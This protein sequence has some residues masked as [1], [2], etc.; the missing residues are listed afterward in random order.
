[1]VCVHSALVTFRRRV[2]M[3][4]SQ[5]HNQLQVDHTWEA[6]VVTEET[7]RNRSLGKDL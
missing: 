7:R 2:L 1:M 5:I 6:L 3:S 4:G